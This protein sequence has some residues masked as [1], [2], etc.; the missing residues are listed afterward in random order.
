ME[1]TARFKGPAACQLSEDLASLWLRLHTS[2]P[3]R[4][5]VQ[6]GKRCAPRRAAILAAK[7]LFIQEF[8]FVV[9]HSY[10]FPLNLGL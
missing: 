7:T 1:T 5:R 6:K 9:A 10:G 8:Q 2:A 3:S 4:R